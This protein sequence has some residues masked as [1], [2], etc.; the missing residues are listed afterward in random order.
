MTDGRWERQDAERNDRTPALEG[1]LEAL[2]RTSARRLPDLEHTMRAARTRSAITWREWI[3]SMTNDTRRGWL[4]PVAVAAVAAIA[5][6]V[7]PISYDK[8]T[9]HEVT[10]TLGAAGLDPAALAPIARE[11]KASLG[12]ES[13]K[14]S[15]EM[16]NGVPRATLIANV[17][18]DAGASA[19][20]VAQAFATSLES[21][22]YHAVAS[23]EAKRERVSGS[24]YAFARDQVIRISMDGKS[25]AELES[26]IR[27]R[28]AE[29]GIP[30][31][32]VSVTEVSTPD[33]QKKKI[34]VGIEHDQLGTEL[35]HAAP[36][37][38]VLTKDGQPVEGK[39]FTVKVMKKS[40]AG[41]S[42]LTIEVMHE[43]R[44]ATAEVSNYES[45]SDAAVA[46]AIE[47]QLLAAGFRVRVQVTGG[48]VEIDPLP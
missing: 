10:L 14:A 21:R 13:V 3:M 24:V 30:N 36:P 7:V 19:A 15:M 39:G 44:S 16:D 42:A 17:P 5:L 45:M 43:G 33:G 28:L 47:S 12:A 1:D 18:A 9:G 40:H 8:T 48:Q 32:S 26:E 20:A 2:R 4:A 46:S 29:S 11:L 27:A 35:E 31:A 25:A 6:L 38:L 23:V 41:A 34:K 37:E 22:G